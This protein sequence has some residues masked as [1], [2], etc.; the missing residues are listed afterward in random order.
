MKLVLAIEYLSLKPFAFLV[1]LGGYNGSKILDKIVDVL[2]RRRILR[3]CDC[4]LLNRGFYAYEQCTDGLLKYVFVPLIFQK[5]KFKLE[6]VLNSVQLTLDFF[7]EKTR[8]V[9]E[10]I[11]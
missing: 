7:N 3:K 8:R 5:K 9:K 10:K 1:F 6:W 11:Q 4:F 2:M